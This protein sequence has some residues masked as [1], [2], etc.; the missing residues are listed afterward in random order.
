MR[1]TRWDEHWNRVKS[2]SFLV[3]YD[4]RKPHAFS[5]DGH[6][7]GAASFICPVCAERLF[8]DAGVCGVPCAHL[9][10][11][12]DSSGDILYA[13]PGMR[14]LVAEAEQHASATGD[15]AMEALR[16]QLGMSVVFFEL[17]GEPHGAGSVESVTLVVDLSASRPDSP[18]GAVHSS[19]TPARREGGFG[20]TLD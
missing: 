2:M 8:S 1:G 15:D 10:L 11:A 5:G 4:P 12:Y 13:V 18:L 14:N 3:A 19:L 6:A 20:A 16:G 17:L 9:V 7:P